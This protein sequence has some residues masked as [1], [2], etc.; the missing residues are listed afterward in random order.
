MDL[1]G[2]QGNSI[3]L[4][5]AGIFLLFWAWGFI[6]KL[7]GLFLHLLLGAAIIAFLY[8]TGIL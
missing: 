5:I 7:G 1:S 3:I 2:V 4:V 8:Y 6:K